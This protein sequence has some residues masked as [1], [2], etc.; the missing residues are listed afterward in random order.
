MIMMDDEIPW[1]CEVGENFMQKI[2]RVFCWIL[3]H[4]WAHMRLHIPRDILRVCDRCGK[5]VDNRADFE[6][7]CKRELGEE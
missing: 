5:I 2:A 3:G 7:F 4:K 6:Q 1:T